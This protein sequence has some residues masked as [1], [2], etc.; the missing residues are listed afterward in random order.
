MIYLYRTATQTTKE[1]KNAQAQREKD[2]EVTVNPFPYRVDGEVGRF[3]FLTH[4]VFAGDEQVF[5]TG[6]DV[7]EPL[8]GKEY[9]RTRG[10][11]EISM[12]FGCVEGSYRKTTALIN[13]VRYHQKDGTPCSSNSRW[14]S[15]AGDLEA[16]LWVRSIG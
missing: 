15:S 5:N 6:R 1:P 2:G 14:G 7:F 10:F 4:S 11:K 8:T 9:Y 13:R 12:I 16:D 3:D